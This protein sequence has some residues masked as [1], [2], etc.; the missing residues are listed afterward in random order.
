MSATGLLDSHPRV[1]Y[2]ALTSLALLLTELAPDAQKKY[3]DQLI[4]I[5]LKLMQE[6]TLIK[7]KTQATS[8]MVNFVR[9]LI[10]EEADLDETS[11]AQK[12]YSVI[13]APYSG[14][15]VETIG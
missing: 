11:D 13:L 3:H 8:C 1:R 9:G 10:D 14:P 4:P 2:E 7:L 12:E 6:E 5:L 15:M